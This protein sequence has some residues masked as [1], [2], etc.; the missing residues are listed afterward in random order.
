MTFVPG[1]KLEKIG[2]DCFMLTKIEKITIPK[3]VTELQDDALG[4]C[5][6]VWVV[7]FET[8]SRLRS[9]GEHVFCLFENLAHINLPEHLKSI[10]DYAFYGCVN[11]KSV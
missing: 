3:G 11:L 10:D 6:S 9:I 4:L 2:T 5:S 8:G 1:S 7:E